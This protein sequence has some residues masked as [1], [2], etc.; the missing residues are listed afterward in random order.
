LKIDESQL[1]KSN[2]LKGSKHKQRITGEDKY[3]T[4]K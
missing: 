3:I 2:N 1:E 4:G